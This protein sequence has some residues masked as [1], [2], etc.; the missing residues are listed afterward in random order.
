MNPR[1]PRR[2][3]LLV[4]TLFLIGSVIGTAGVDE[5]RTIEVVAKRFAF[6]PAVIE[7]DEGE[8][9]RLVLRSA[10]VTHGFEIDGYDVKI[11]VPKGGEPVSVEF[12]ADRAG[13]FGI[14]CSE[15]CG[16]GHRR[17]RGE[18]VVRAADGGAR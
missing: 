10:D 3:G 5:P 15:Y 14:E 18:L 17:M 12:V 8:S 2:T 13:S 4:G 11:E 16:S 9:V 1:R 6:D 7:V